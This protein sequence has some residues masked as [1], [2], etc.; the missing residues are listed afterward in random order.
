MALRALAR[1][2]NLAFPEDC[3]V[4]GTR[5]SN[6]SRVPVC[7]NC[8][9]APQPMVAEF[10]CTQCHTPFLNDAP[11]RPN[12]LC[13]LC[14]SGI[15]MYQAVY[16]YGFYEGALRKLVHL[17]KY[18]RI[19]TL[20][21]PLG[22][23]LVAALPRGERFDLIV[24][25][26]LHWWRRYRRGFNQAALLAKPV[27]RATGWPVEQLLRRVKNTGAQAGLTRS[28]RRRNVAGAFRVTDAERLRGK[29]VLLI[30][31]VF[32]TGAT[33]AAATAALRRAGA[34]RVAVL[35]LARVDRRQPA[36]ALQTN[37]VAQLAASGV[38]A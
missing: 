19:S 5:L 13:A 11:L 23:L 16:S 25:L 21:E 29:R 31:D 22:Q 6:F 26:P 36:L 27:S 34:A 17:F 2:L 28:A 4:C 30:D 9:H 18:Q 10:A 8:L 37:A 1:L 35:T 14:R 24:P 3:R 12:G 20:A 7:P 15:A 32:T 38:G 33:A